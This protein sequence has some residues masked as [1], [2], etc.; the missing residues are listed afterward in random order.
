[1]SSIDAI[2]VDFAGADGVEGAV[3]NAKPTAAGRQIRYV[4]GS[5][6]KMSSFLGSFRRGA[7]KAWFDIVR[8]S[9]TV[10]TVYSVDASLLR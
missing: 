8:G 9:C 5:I 10:S 1:M 2:P 6:L 3:I 4:P 7:Q